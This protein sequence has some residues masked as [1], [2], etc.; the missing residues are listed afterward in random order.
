MPK[1]ASTPVISSHSE[2]SSERP[3]GHVALNRSRSIEQHSYSC[4]VSEAVPSIPPKP[5]VSIADEGTITIAPFSRI[6]S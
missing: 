1:S 4:F 6:A 3:P 2:E 5:I